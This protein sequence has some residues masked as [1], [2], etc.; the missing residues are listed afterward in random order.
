MFYL[1]FSRHLRRQAAYEIW[2]TSKWKFGFIYFHLNPF[3]VTSFPEIEIAAL[4]SDLFW[5]T[6]WREKGWRD[7][8][9]IQIFTLTSTKSHMLLDVWGDVKSQNE[10]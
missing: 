5:A 6:S 4:L 8:R 9:W 10:K 2:L 1:D 7:N 3:R